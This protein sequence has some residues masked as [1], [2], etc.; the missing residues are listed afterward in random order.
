MPVAVLRWT[1][2]RSTLHWQ[3]S[4]PPGFKLV[5]DKV[6]KHLSAWTRMRAISSRNEWRRQ[7]FGIPRF[8]FYKHEIRWGPSNNLSLEKLMS[9]QTIT[10]G[11][12]TK[13]L[14]LQFLNISRLCSFKQ[15]KT[16]SILV[17]PLPLLSWLQLLYESIDPEQSCAPG[18]RAW[19]K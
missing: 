7:T 15:T 5:Q 4:W 12:L 14:S 8:P 2:L 10:N 16:S 13:N 9:F 18:H 3:N 11:M 19:R 1:Q 6:W 17:A